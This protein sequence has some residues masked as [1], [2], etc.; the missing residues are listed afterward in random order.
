MSILQIGFE[1]SGNLWLWSIIEGLL[2]QAGVPHRSFIQRQP[3]YEI[4]KHWDL[5][6]Q[7][8]AGVDRLEIG[9]AR[10]YC[11]I[12]PIFLSPLEDVEAYA[13]ECSHV[14][15]QSH[16]HD[17]ASP[18]VL[19]KFSKVVYIARDPRDALVSMSR[20]VFLP[21]ARKYFPAAEKTPEEYIEKRLAGFMRNWV[22]HA[23]GYLQSQR[24]ARIHFIFY[25]RLLRSFDEEA[26]RLAEYLG[27]SLD[28]GSAET[29]KKNAAFA[30]MKTQNP[31]HVSEGTAGQWKARLSTAQKKAALGIAGPLLELLN[32]PPPRRDPE[33]IRK[34]IADAK[35]KPLGDVIRRGYH[36]LMK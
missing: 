13:R 25:E 23:G 35:R 16:F 24:E 20:Y 11:L 19:S 9:P 7:G 15:C 12:Y 17:E 29:V 22:R 36:F 30:A 2:G 21:F 14:W 5:S 18:S 32:D 33:R 6:F 3:I 10:S 26:G 31:Y 1:R 34:M 27:L 8:Q 4:A 28:R